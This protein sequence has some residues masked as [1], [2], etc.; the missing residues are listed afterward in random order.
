M[1][2]L[3]QNPS[4]AETVHFCQELGQA[5]LAYGAPAHRL[6]EV[7]RVL[8]EVYGLCGESFSTPTSLMT[9]IHAKGEDP[10]PSLHRVHSNEIHLQRLSQL[11][12]LFN[13]VADAHLT[14]REGRSKLKEI[15]QS[16]APYGTWTTLLSFGFASGSAARFFGGGIAEILLATM[17]GVGLGVLALLGKYSPTLRRLFEPL[18]GF[19][20][21][22]LAT[23]GATFFTT[24]SIDRA[25][26]GGL[27]ILVPGFTLTVAVAELA[28]R[29]LVSGT[30]RLASAVLSFLM[31]GFGVAF[32]RTVG[33]GLAGELPTMET[34]PL[35][36]WTLYAILPIAST[37]IGILFQV[38]RRDLGW[39]FL[40][41]AASF[42]GVSFGT[43]A[44]GPL[45]GVFFGAFCVGAASNAVARITQRPAST[46]RLPGLLFLVP[47]ALGFLSITS[48]MEGD[49]LQGIES[50]FQTAMAAIALVC[51]LLV[52]NAALPSRKAL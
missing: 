43:D 30:A 39:V 15:L 44:F 47:G 8:T 14:P 1:N 29:N 24:I 48:L 21:A 2:P 33:H 27:I 42:F 49:A 13:Q 19:T 28:T 11:D 52:S 20:V 22:F 36:Q 5:L 12:A 38:D 34:L 4:Q 50:V 51:G 41:S 26:L 9:S 46:T 17:T 18:G 31:I 7:L 10:I 40:V 23:I 32:G 6:E 45:L 35:P 3:P 37:T 16:P 25:T